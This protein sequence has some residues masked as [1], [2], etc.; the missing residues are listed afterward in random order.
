M[1]L[2][3]DDVADL[4]DELEELETANTLQDER[5]N[6]VDDVINEHNNDINGNQFRCDCLSS[7]YNESNVPFPSCTN[8][9]S[10]P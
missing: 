7:L 6:T 3:E 10:R 4:Q 1:T 9:C 8:Y 2:L 5:L